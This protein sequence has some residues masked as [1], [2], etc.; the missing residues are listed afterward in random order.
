MIYFIQQENQRKDGTGILNIRVGWFTSYSRRTSARMEQVY[1]LNIRVGWYTVLHILTR[2]CIQYCDSYLF[3]EIGTNGFLEI[4]YFTRI[5]KLVTFQGYPKQDNL[6]HMLILFL[7]L[8]FLRCVKHKGKFINYPALCQFLIS[9]NLLPV[10]INRKW[11][12]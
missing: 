4:Y 7:I 6:I 11:T 3:Y 10:L 12:V 8:N 9:E 1:I 2:S 5:T